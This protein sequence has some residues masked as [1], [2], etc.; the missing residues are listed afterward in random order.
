[1]VA[2]LSGGVKTS[3]SIFF[4]IQRKLHFQQKCCCR[5][6]VVVELP[7][8]DLSGTAALAPPQTPA[9]DV[10]VDFTMRIKT[11]P[12]VF[13]EKK[14]IRVEASNLATPRRSTAR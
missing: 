3:A 13:Q 5:V 1:M 12:T 4:C 2:K 10:E 14:A 7:G 11:F 6:V 8:L 9:L